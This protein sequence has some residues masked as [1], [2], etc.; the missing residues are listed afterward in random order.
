VLQH[1][2]HQVNEK[3]SGGLTEKELEYNNR[4]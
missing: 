4:N 1:D 3:L 2:L